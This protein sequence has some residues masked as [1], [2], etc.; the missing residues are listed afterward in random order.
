MTRRTRVLT[1][2]IF[3]G[4]YSSYKNLIKVTTL[5]ITNED[6]QVLAPGQTF[7]R[8]FDLRQLLQNVQSGPSP[9][10]P[11][12]ITI[13]LPQ[14]FQ[15]ARTTGPYDVPAAAAP[16]LKNGHLGDFAAA[17]LIEI[18]LTAGS[19]ID[20]LTFPVFQNSPA[21]LTVP[22]DGVQLDTTTCSGDNAT[23]LNDA[24]FD[25]GVYAQSASLAADDKSNTFYTQYFKDSDR[26]IV[27]VF[28]DNAL[29]ALKGG[30]SYHIDLYC[31]DILNLCDPGGRVL[32]Y[33][34]TP[35]FVGSAF[36]IL[37][38]AAKA[39]GRAPPACSFP[40][41][42]QPSASTSHVLLHLVMTISNILDSNVGNN[43]YGVTSCSRIPTTTT[44]DAT[45]NA[46]SYAQL[47]IAQWAYGHGGAPYGGAPC[48]PQNGEID[49]N[50]KR[51]TQ[52]DVVRP[53]TE[54]RSNRRTLSLRQSQQDTPEGVVKAAQQCTG[55][56]LTLIQNAA[57]NARSLAATARDNKD[58]DLFKVY[59]PRSEGCWS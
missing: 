30:P 35:S 24:I 33:S 44:V 51:D 1:L 6:L 27:K 22:A 37:C 59:V 3:I 15:G 38:P 50:L 48:V 20:A 53:T 41:G 46:D 23:Q 29:K 52:I 34:Y 55:D 31:T 26:L 8:I 4:S 13:D 42:R 28:A 19:L 18:T 16:D 39:L 57:A 36:I 43:Y 56:Q 2:S 21:D 14:S 12:R 47:G 40:S 17:K 32:G 11:K 7:T 5:G 45:R 58:D 9:F 49:V 25:A 54:K 10:N